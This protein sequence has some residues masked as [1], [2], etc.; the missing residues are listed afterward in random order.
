MR[1]DTSRVVLPYYAFLLCVL[2]DAPADAVAIKGGLRLPH[3]A[4]L[5][6]LT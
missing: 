1:N 2:R 6:E 3:S 4:A 5:A